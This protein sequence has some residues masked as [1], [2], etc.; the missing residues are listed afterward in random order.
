MY[1]VHACA[2]VKIVKYRSTHNFHLLGN[3]RLYLLLQ[4]PV[5]QQLSNLIAHD[6]FVLLFHIKLYGC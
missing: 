2:S 3:P 1:V 5:N 4:I 6:R